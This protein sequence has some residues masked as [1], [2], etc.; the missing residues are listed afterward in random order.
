MPTNGK[1]TTDRVKEFQLPPFA[2]PPPPQPL[3]KSEQVS[4]EVAARIALVQQKQA[5]DLERL[6]GKVAALNSV[7]PTV[8]QIT[9]DANHS[10]QQLTNVIL[11]RGCDIAEDCIEL[12][13]EDEG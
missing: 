9:G 5:L 12:V 10:L 2:D 3:A 8:Q 4:N 1:Q 6:L 7:M 11:Q 13:I